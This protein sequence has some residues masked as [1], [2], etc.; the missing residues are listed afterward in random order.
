VFHCDWWGVGVEGMHHQGLSQGG[1][2]HAVVA[3]WQAPPSAACMQARTGI[4][5][6]I[7]RLW[8]QVIGA[9]RVVWNTKGGRIRSRQVWPSPSQKGWLSTLLGG[10]SAQNEA[11]GRH[12]QSRVWCEGCGP[13]VILLVE[14]GMLLVVSY[15]RASLR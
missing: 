13:L 6:D 5:A 7:T 8:G 11:T 2:V 4:D 15:I 10:V 12:Q 1:R 9:E 14:A 3:G